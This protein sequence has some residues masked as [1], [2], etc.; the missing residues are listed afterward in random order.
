MEIHQVV[1]SAAPGDAITDAALEFRALLRRVGPS[2]VFASH[3]DPN[4]TSEV[5]PLG[6]Y[7]Q[8]A[9]AGGGTNLLVVHLSIGDAPL[10]RFLADRRERVAV[11]YHNITPSSFF[12]P[13]D[14]HF[15]RLLALGRDQLADLR[16]RVGLAIAVSE[17][18]AAE[19]RALGYRNVRVLPL[20]VDPHRLRGVVPDRAVTAALAA[21]PG[22]T[23]LFVGQLLPHKRLDLLVEAYHVLVTKLVPEAS[24]VLVGPPRLPAYEKALRVLL[25]ELNLPGVE[26]TG[27]V[28][29]A[30]LAAYYRGAT[31]FVT[32]S[33]HEGLCLPVL[34]AMA[35][36]LPVV[37]RGTAA[38]PETIGT[39][40]LVLP[41]DA[42]PLLLAE[43]M[44]AL[45]EAPELRA[46][47]A[48]AGQHRLAT[49]FDAD[50]ARAGFLE[51]VLEAA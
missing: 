48:A 35:F 34:E 13:Y 28:P 33:E 39:G 36:D 10:G 3:R 25:R 15:T 23:L 50:T 7:E 47:L 27:S 19:L 11:V 49:G 29:V 6:S 41:V 43:A 1:V 26:I 18:N 21:R 8:L 5:R 20:V 38:L 9:S 46:E 32:A 44:A 24:L 51:A 31:A 12:A 2:E 17:F 14:A 30:E 22:P 37:A 45:L 4:I 42:D 16:D 40:G